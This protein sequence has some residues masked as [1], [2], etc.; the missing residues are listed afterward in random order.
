[1]IIIH[2]MNDV[3]YRVLYEDGDAEYINKVECTESV[4]LYM[5]LGSV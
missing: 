1:M 4:D 3:L 2:N 5:K